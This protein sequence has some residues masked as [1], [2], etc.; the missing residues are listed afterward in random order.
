MSNEKCSEPSIGCRMQRAA[1]NMHHNTTAHSTAWANSNTEHTLSAQSKTLYCIALHCIGHRHSD[2]QT[3]TTARIDSR[4]PML[5]AAYCDCSANG[6]VALASRVRC[7]AAMQ[8]APSRVQ[9]STV[10]LQQC[11]Y[12]SAA[13][14]VPLRRCRCNQCRC[15]SAAATV[16]LQQCRCNSAAATVPLQQCHSR[17]CLLAIHTFYSCCEG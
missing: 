7:S 9:Q 4:T 16:P 12:N 2:E 13:A 8:N 11:R 1:C 6:A 3:S 5:S 15:N 14:T 10:P 17:S